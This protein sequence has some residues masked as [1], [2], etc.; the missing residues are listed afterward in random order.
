MVFR[1]YG[2]VVPGYFGIG[3]AVGGDFGDWRA[4]VEGTLNSDMFDDIN[5]TMRAWPVARSIFDANER[6]TGW[7]NINVNIVNCPL[8]LSS[9]FSEQVLF[10]NRTGFSMV[11]RNSASSLNVL[12]FNKRDQIFYHG[13]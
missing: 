9:S 2:A 7:I 5:V 1:T 11:P 8:S 6:T 3:Q 4:A 13:T 10:S 12:I